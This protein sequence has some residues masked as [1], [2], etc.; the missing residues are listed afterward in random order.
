MGSRVCVSCVRSYSYIVTH[1]LDPGSGN[2]L[3]PTTPGPGTGRG[4]QTPTTGHRAERC[5]C[6]DIRELDNPCPT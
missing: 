5:H 2:A 1:K 6:P 3:L 4:T